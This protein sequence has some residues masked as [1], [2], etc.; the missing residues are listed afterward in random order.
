M[1]L[2]KAKA[3]AGKA[4]ADAKTI[5]GLETTGLTPILPRTGAFAQVLDPHLSKNRS[6]RNLHTCHNIAE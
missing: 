1:T 3:P 2:D 4:R 6:T 5:N